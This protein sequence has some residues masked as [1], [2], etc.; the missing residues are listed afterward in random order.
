MNVAGLS[1][2]PKSPAQGGIS[3]SKMPIRRVGDSYYTSQAVN[4]RAT[5]QC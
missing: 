5:M 4:P 3:P 2:C 1:A